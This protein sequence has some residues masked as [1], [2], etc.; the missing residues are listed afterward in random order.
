MKIYFILY[1]K[2][3]NFLYLQSHADCQ[4]FTHTKPARCNLAL[5]NICTN[6]R[7]FTA[8]VNTIVIQKA[9]RFNIPCFVIAIFLYLNGV[10]FAVV[11]SEKLDTIDEVPLL[12]VLLWQSYDF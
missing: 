3:D 12:A 11:V 7:A 1:Q 10:Q 6:N 4:C 8:L 9:E 5:L 2:A